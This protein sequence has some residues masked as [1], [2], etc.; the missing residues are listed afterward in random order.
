MEA[1]RAFA[2]QQEVIQR[3]SKA[4]GIGYLEATLEWVKKYSETVCNVVSMLEDEV[5]E[6]TVEMLE[7]GI[8]SEHPDYPLTTVSC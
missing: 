7:V 4:E 5:G 1:H 8:R 2:V 3:Y 6:V